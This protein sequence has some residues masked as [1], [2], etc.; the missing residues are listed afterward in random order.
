MITFGLKRHFKGK[1]SRWYHKYPRAKINNR[2]GDKIAHKEAY[3]FR[4]NWLDDNFSFISWK[5][6]DKF[7][8]S[9]VGRPINKVFSEFVKRCDSTTYNLKKEFYSHISRKEDITPR[10]GGFYI[11]N[12]ILNYKKKVNNPVPKVY[13][14]DFEDYNRRNLPKLGP[15]CKKCEATH[16]KQFLGE[17][18]LCYC[19]SIRRVYI[20]EN[21]VFEDNVKLQLHYK[22]CHIYGVGQGVYDYKCDE[23]SRV[24]YSTT[25]WFRGEKPSK[26]IFITKIN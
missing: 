23:Y 15:I 21:S 8:M 22:P 13:T 5:D 25:I 17:F 20:V 6:I 24:M 19:D 2:G 11:T 1:K 7:L 10:L 9:N 26:F 16:T 14:T 12:G 3:W 18:K 4:S